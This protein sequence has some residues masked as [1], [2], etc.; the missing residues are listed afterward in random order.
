MSRL[1][2][3]LERLFTA[4]DRGARGWL[5]IFIRTALAFDQDDGAVMSRSIAYYALFSLFP[6]ILVLLSFSGRFL[7]S[8][9]AQQAVID[10][11]QQYLPGATDILQANMK[12][13]VQASTTTGILAIVGLIWSASGVFTAIYRSVNRAWGNPKSQL[14]WAEKLFGVAVVLLFGVLLLGTTIISTIVTVLQRWQE[15]IV[16]WKP[17]LEPGATLLSGWLPSIAPAVVSVVAF[18]ILYR[19]IPRNKVRWRDVWLAGLVAG[20]IWELARQVYTWYLGNIA[21]YSLIYGSVGAIIGFLLW[22]YLSAMILLIG[23]EFAAQLTHWRKAGRPI[24]TRPPTQWME[25]WQK[26]E[27]H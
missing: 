22:A 8:D 9:D 7:A 6:L 24:E 4:A 14:F 13:V 1:Q 11:V 2:D 27:N 3:S 5:T 16:S 18:I 10:F 26:W 21:R 25:E 19:T 17:A 23:A 15:T 20:L 12:Q